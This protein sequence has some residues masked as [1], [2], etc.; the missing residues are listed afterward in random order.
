MK[1]KNKTVLSE[2]SLLGIAFIL[3]A[4][5]IFVKSS[6][7]SITPLWLMAARF[8]V[9]ALAISIFFFKKLKL[10]NRGTLLAGVVCGVLIY[11]AF[12]FQTIGI[13][14]TTASKNALLTTAYV[15]LVPFIFWI[16]IRIKPKPTQIIA[17]VL[18]F[19]GITMLMSNNIFG[20]TN[21]K[22]ELF[23]DFLTLICGLFFGVHISLLG[24]Y[25]KKHDAIALT[26]VQMITCAFISLVAALLFED[27]PRH[28]SG[29]TIGAILYLGLLSTC[30]AYLVQTVA[31]KYT[32]PSHASLIMSLEC[33]IGSIL[34]V[35]IFKD[36][37]TPLM[38]AGS[39]VTFASVVLSQRSNRN[40]LSKA[41]LSE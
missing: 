28:M 15:V 37:F 8:I 35:I 39:A 10:I 22:D 30:L 41:L 12:A 26:I 27:V 3:G 5:F 25:S 21:G 29:Q 23:G 36:V 14:Y 7:D 33:V 19:A 20:A 34:S 4:A 6:L 11:V 13:Q 38:W 1:N 16:L 17:A 31:Q 24:I 32:T 40:E 18:C 9:A 2:L